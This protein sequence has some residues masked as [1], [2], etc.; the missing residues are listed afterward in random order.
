MLFL[1]FVMVY[2]YKK[3]DNK[4]CHASCVDCGVRSQSLFSEFDGDQMAAVDAVKAC[5]TFKKNQSIFLE[6]SIPRGVFCLR[7]G[8]IKIYALGAEGKEQIVRVA[9]EGS[10]LGVKALFSNEPYIV[11]A[12]ALEECAVC[13]IAK[14]DFFS[15]IDLNST[16]TN[17][18]MMEMSRELHEKT[19]FITNMAQKS[20]HDRLAFAFLLLDEI[21][22]KE[23]INLSREDLANFVGT[24]TETLIRLISQF[25]DEGLIRTET[26]KIWVTD[27]ESLLELTA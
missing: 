12:M 27:R 9:K 21:Y 6:G 23:P 14:D 7:K 15:M 3:M 11:S 16:L 20:V 4:N 17:G 19:K 18:I 24:A 5:S 1:N 10:I 25:K 8:K 13:Y 22:G 2:G 26:R